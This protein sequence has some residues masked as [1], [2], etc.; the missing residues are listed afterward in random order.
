LRLLVV[1][2]ILFAGLLLLKET[3]SQL[4]EFDAHFFTPSDVGQ[5]KDTLAL[6]RPLTDPSKLNSKGLMS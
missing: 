3:L 6:G 5:K 1:R 2:L 4:V